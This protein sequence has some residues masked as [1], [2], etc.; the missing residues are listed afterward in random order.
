ML[1][2]NSLPSNRTFGNMLETLD[3]S[4]PDVG[5]PAIGRGA[6]RGVARGRSFRK[7]LTKE[8]SKEHQVPDIKGNGHSKRV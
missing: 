4:L 6:A 3:R 1:P 8:F 5:D 2:D 7:Q